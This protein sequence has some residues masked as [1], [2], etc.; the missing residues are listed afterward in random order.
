M[1]ESKMNWDLTSYFPEF[2][3]KEMKEFKKNLIAD[4]NT[5]VDLARSLEDISPGNLDYWEKVF[6]SGEELSRRYSHLRSYVGCLSA[7]D[8]NNEDYLKEEADMIALGSRFEKL[9]VEILGKLA[10][11]DRDTVDRLKALE[12]LATSSYYIERLFEESRK[13]MTDEKEVLA[14]DLAV[15]GMKSWG[16]LYNTV[17]GKLMFDMKFPDGKVKRLPMSQRRSLME[18]PD[19]EIR[20]QAFYGGNNAWKEVEDVAASCLNA[21]S[22]TRLTLNEHRGISHFLDVALYQ[23]SISSETLNAMFEAIYEEIEVPKNILRYKAE[24]IGEKVISWYDL[25]AP[26]D[27]KDRMAVDWDNAKSMV[28]ESFTSAYPKLG[29]FVDDVYKRNWIDWEPREG[30]RPGGFCTGSMLTNES[31]I[32]MTYNKSLGDVLT[33]AHEAGHAF[34]SFIM[35]DQR[36]YR[37]YYPMTLAETASTFGE[38]ILGRGILG[39]IDISDQEKALMLDTEINHGAIYLI[40]IP[41]RFEFEKSLYEER[42][43]GIL[44][45]SRLNELMEETQRKVFGDVL[46]E[47]DPFFWASKLHFYITGVTFYNFPYTFGYLLSRAL[48]NM[49]EKE[50][51]GFL[52][53]YENFLEISG[54]FSCEE[55][56]RRSIDEDITDKNFWSRSIKTLEEPLRNLKEII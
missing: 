7:A 4:L 38:M 28:S 36:P 46:D 29:E 56:V 49:F 16:R 14:S 27:I 31:R 41:V 21:I 2:N 48:F 25:G 42:E 47:T 5:I 53:K 11:A 33:L 1:S 55:V 20:K 50:G 34:H 54:S 15:D 52:E 43:N 17:S 45:V 13:R 22:G 10:N 23:S 26:L 8:G 35:K 32:F 51:E 9:G 3:G 39:N 24:L 40:D 19:R 30:K 12:S 44:N 18:D 37:R 6:I